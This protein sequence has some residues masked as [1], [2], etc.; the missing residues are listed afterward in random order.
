MRFFLLA[1]LCL[2]HLPAVFAGVLLPR[3]NGTATWMDTSLSA[4]QRADALLPHL[5]WDEKVAQMGGI[6][7]LL[8]AN[9]TFNQTLYDS[10]YPLQ[11]GIL[12]YGSQL[13]QAQTVLPYANMVRE[14]QRN[15]S[16]VPWITVTDSVNSIYLPGGTMFPA[17]L[18]LSTSWN[19]TLY[20]QVVAAIRDENVALGT[21]WV[22]S[23]ELEVSKDPRY[24]RVGEQYGEDVY[25]IGE[26]AAQYVKTMQERD[27]DGYMKVATTVKHFLYGQGSGGVNTASMD[28]GVN[29]L[30]NDLALPFIRVFKEDPASIMISYASIDRI[31]MSMNKAMIQGMLRN[32]MGFQG[33]VM[34]DAVAINHL[35]TQSLVASSYKDA[36]IK[37]VKAGMQLELAPQQPACFPY[38]VNSSNDTSIVE[39]VDEAVRQLL[40]IKFETGMF[41]QPLPTLEN[42]NATLRSAGHLDTNLQASRESIVLLQNNGILPRPK[43][44]K[45]ALLGPFADIL[46]PG[47]YA[48]STSANPE[49]GR[50]LRG[51]LEAVLGSESVQYVQGVNIRTDS[52]NSI[53]GI[54]QAVAA[55][56]E[57][58]VAIV[59]LGSLS[60]YF[61]DGNVAQRT[62]GEFFSHP[63]LGFPG[64][65]Q[66]L[67]DAVLDTGVP[68]VLVLNGG[69]AFVL[70]NSTMRANA[71]LHTFL[72]GEF[73]ADALVEIL[74]GQVNPSGKLTVTMPQAEG[75]FP[76][77]YDF[78]PSDAEGGYAATVAGVCTS[79]WS[80]PCLTRGGA[81]MA[82]GFGLGYTT[83]DIAS[84]KAVVAGGGNVTV[85]CTVTN[86]GSV[87]GKE[88]VQVY[89]RQQ[90]SNL[91]ELPNKRLVRFQKVELSPGQSQDV[92]FS[93]DRN[94]LGY[95]VNAQYQVDSGNYTFWVGSSSRA[96]DLMNVTLTL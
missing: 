3:Q 47:S 17:T 39:M 69:Q 8:S 32:E 13:N 72:G 11:H 95:Y 75:A 84:S 87:T 45:V 61:L 58:D 89:Y 65:Q 27:E 88:V 23:P 77:Y 86:T 64:Q 31:P 78:L 19:L 30:Y 42:L 67:L 82:F 36:A 6:R 52:G 76:V 33:L 53:A 55:A 10:L 48:P 44:G 25:L 71:I 94:E 63:D 85:S 96:Q 37:A 22:L 16:L 70:N 20:E 51:S 93:I 38:L 81:T 91:I 59:S 62:D 83:F 29:H 56:K 40:I 50:T 5:T 74:Q 12:S 9:S 92:S 15:N 21:H 18:S 57:A 90:Y 49:N 54:Q 43:L 1:A 66:Q 41:D 68:T 26:F 80:F 60:V 24:G 7:Q 14:Q 79:D 4:Q 2:Q 35:Y 34:S 73:T 28:G 46:D